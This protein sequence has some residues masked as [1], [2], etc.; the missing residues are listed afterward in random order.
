[1]LGRRK[2]DKKY[3]VVFFLV[4]NVICLLSRYIHTVAHTADDT[5]AATYKTRE[6][7]DKSD[8]TNNQSFGLISTIQHLCAMCK[9]FI[10]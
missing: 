3:V 9:T 4:H 5:A 8:L 2:Q 7:R 1:M 10:L 6:K